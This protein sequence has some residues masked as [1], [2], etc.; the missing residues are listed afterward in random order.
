[1]IVNYRNFG[2]L[3][4]DVRKWQ[5]ELPSD[6]DLIVGIP[7]SGLLPGNLLALRLNLPLTT[8]D[9]LKEQFVLQSGRRLNRNKNFSHINNVLIVDDSVNTGKTIEE[10]KTQVGEID[11]SKNIYY[12]AVYA[13]KEGRQFVDT[14]ADVVRNPRV[15][16]WNMMHHP[17]LSSWGV[18]LEGILCRDPLPSETDDVKK[19]RRFISEVEPK[20]VPSKEIGYI[21]ACRAKKYRELTEEWLSKHGIEYG[22]LVL[23][24]YSSM[25]ARRDAGNHAEYKANIYENAESDLFIENSEYQAKKIARIARKSVFCAEVNRMY[26]PDYLTR[27]GNGLANSVDDFKSSP[28]RY[29]WMLINDPVDFFK[30]AY[31]N[32]FTP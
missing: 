31:N 2:H 6:L 10:V 29:I 20:V 15:F 14:Y 4:E 19:Y 30:K 28:R 9:G 8:V 26:R 12:G 25:D 17:L 32:I 13:S 16:E 18:S 22:Q 7:R 23:M 27:A 1:M 11:F 3:N 5:R 24:D 21:V